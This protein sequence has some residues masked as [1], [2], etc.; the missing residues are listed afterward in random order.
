MPLD[1]T[2]L[3]KGV[4]KA[5]CAGPETLICL[6]RDRTERGR[7]PGPKRW[8]SMKLAFAPKEMEYNKQEEDQ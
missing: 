7:M 5:S 1:S 2:T 3:W 6:R 8:G 4:D